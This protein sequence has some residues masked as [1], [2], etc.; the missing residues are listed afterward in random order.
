MCIRQPYTAPT[1]AQIYKA[2]MRSK[3]GD[4]WERDELRDLH[5]DPELKD[6]VNTMLMRDIASRYGTISVKAP[7][8]KLARNDEVRIH[9]FM[10]GK[11]DWSGINRRLVVVSSMPYVSS[12]CVD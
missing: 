4:F 12:V 5:I 3:P 10:H 1:E 11:V 2:I 7:E 8:D 9:P 6:L